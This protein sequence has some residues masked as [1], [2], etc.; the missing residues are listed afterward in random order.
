MTTAAQSGFG[1]LPTSPLPSYVFGETFT[2]PVID[3]L[4]GYLKAVLNVRAGAAW[5]SIGGTN[6]VVT[7]FAGNPDEIAFV[8]SDLP[9]LFMWRADEGQ[10]KWIADDWHVR[11]TEIHVTWIFPVVTGSDRARNKTHFLN[12]FT[13]VVQQAIAQERDASFVIPGDPEPQA[14]TYGSLLLTFTQHVKL[15]ARGCAR[16]KVAKDIPANS[17]SA[18]YD[19]ITTKLLII[20]RMNWDISSVAEGSGLDGTLSN[21]G[22]VLQLFEVA[23]VILSVTPNTGPLAGGTTVTIA[24]HQFLDTINDVDVSAKIDGIACTAVTRIDE[25]TLTIITPP[26]LTIGAKDVTV[27]NSNGCSVTSVGAFTYT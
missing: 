25:D 20:E 7:T 16:A 21:Q 11:E 1:I 4:L 15:D 8:D 3:I 5:N 12:G 27:I 26:G 14:A 18:L 13:S 17:D 24:G 22:L 6:A 23:P 10:A 19:A 2:D 9:A